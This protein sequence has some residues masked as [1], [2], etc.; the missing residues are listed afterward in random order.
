L[1]YLAAPAMRMLTGETFG[2]GYAIV[3]WVVAGAFLLGL[4]QRYQIALALTHQSM[5]IMYVTLFS[6]L[7][8]IGL[9]WVLLP[10]YGYQVAAVTTLISYL[11]LLLGTSV[12]SKRYFAWPFP[13]STFLRTFFA[14]GALVGVLIAVDSLMHWDALWRL[15]ALPPIGIVVYLFVLLATGEVRQSELEAMRRSAQETWA[16]RG[17][18]VGAR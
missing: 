3:P 17:F 18:T 10:K 8:N 9:N 1:G 14:A 16:S 4:Q 15:V 11:V 5:K 6:G 12:W 13:W 7:F 2:E